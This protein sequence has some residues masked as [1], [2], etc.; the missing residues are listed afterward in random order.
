MVEIWGKEYKDEKL[1]EYFAILLSLPE[2]QKAPNFKDLLKKE[3]IVDFIMKKDKEFALEVK[4]HEHKLIYCLTR[5]NWKCNVCKN[6]Y[7]SNQPTF[8]CS[9]CDYNMCDN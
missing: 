4:E 1:L 7:D 3:E 2:G 6:D 8:F 9:L 5:F